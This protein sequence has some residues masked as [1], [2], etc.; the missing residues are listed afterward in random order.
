[1]PQHTDPTAWEADSNSADASPSTQAYSVGD[2]QR[3]FL[4]L[5][6]RR[7]HTSGCPT[8]AVKLTLPTEPSELQP[9]SCGARGMWD[10][11]SQDFC[12]VKDRLR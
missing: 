7:R 8:A 1:M 9:W 10:P 3:A 6:R 5:W 2:R 11:G 4:E 12:L